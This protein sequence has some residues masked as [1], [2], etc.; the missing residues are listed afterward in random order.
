MSELASAVI[1]D[2]FSIL[3]DTIEI[4]WSSL[5]LRFIPTEGSE[6]VSFPWSKTRKV[7][8]DTCSNAMYASSTLCID[9]ARLT[10]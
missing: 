10:K 3:V 8:R 7:L 4:V 6:S 9:V 1:K 2:T 5:Q